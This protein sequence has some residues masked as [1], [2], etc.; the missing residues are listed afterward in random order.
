[1]FILFL[2][3]KQAELLDLLKITGQTAA[4]AETTY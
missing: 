3:W 2:R 1:M 4:A